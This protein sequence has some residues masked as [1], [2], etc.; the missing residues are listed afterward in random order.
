MWDFVV[1]ENDFTIRLLFL[2]IY[3]IRVMRQTLAFLELNDCIS[4]QGIAVFVR[5]IVSVENV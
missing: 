1:E 3:F 5:E 4:E 2:K